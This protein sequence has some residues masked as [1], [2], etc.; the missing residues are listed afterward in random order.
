MPQLP[1]E[2]VLQIANH[3]RGLQD[4]QTTKNLR[5]T[6][7]ALVATC[8]EILFETIILFPDRKSLGNRKHDWASRLNVENILTRMQ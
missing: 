2:V 3:T 7:R 5:L 6:C 4:L 8:T 1:L